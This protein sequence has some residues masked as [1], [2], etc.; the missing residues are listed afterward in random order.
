MPKFPF[1]SVNVLS[2][3]DLKC[4]VV[5]SLQCG[6]RL[7]EQSISVGTWICSCLIN[8]ISRWVQ[9]CF[10]SPSETDPTTRLTGFRTTSGSWHNEQKKNKKKR[11]QKR[12]KV[13]QEKSRD[14]RW[15]SPILSYLSE[16]MFQ[17][18]RSSACRG[19]E[20]PSIRCRSYIKNRTIGSDGIS[21]QVVELVA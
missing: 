13:Y 15:C 8:P 18:Y 20:L 14:F 19:H 21:R 10:V 6:Q 5:C 1:N 17:N 4:H 7:T 3:F 2:M 9:H 12:V 16:K 11:R